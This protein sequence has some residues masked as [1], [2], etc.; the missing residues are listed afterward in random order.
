M[1]CFGHH[2][3]AEGIPEGPV[4]L[5]LNFLV[6]FALFDSFRVV[7]FVVYVSC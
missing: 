1:V 5:L 6:G 7:G 3:A 4:R 2:R